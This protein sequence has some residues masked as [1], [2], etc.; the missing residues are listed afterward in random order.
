MTEP[1]TVTQVSPLW[2]RLD[3]APSPTPALRLASYTPV[4]GDRVSVVRQ[5]SQMNV[6]GKF[7]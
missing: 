2:V 6:L 7:I 4:L 3:S 1:A 5:G